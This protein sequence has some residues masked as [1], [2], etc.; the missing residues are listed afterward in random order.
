MWVCTNC[1]RLKDTNQQA[2]VNYKST[3]VPVKEKPLKRPD[4]DSVK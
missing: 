4:A 3:P 2:D 1:D